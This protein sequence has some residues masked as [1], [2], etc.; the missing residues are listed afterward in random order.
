MGDRIF[1]GII[2]VVIGLL[3][4]IVLYPL[5]LVVIN[6]LSDANAV[7][8]GKVTFL[9]VGFNLDAYAETFKYDNVISGY[10]NSL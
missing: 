7:S 9:P 5:W 2:Y 6:S 3:V 10:L 8:L 4:L 1:N